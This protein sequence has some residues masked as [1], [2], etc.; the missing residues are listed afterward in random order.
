MVTPDGQKTIVQSPYMLS[1]FP[2][3]EELDLDYIASAKALHTTALRVDTAEK[4]MRHAKKEGVTTSFD[5]EKHV[6]NYGFEKLAPLIKLTD[7]LL[8]NK[9]GALTLTGAN[10]L[11]EAAE[12]LISLGPKLVVITR[13]DK[14][15]LVRTIHETLEVPAFKVIAIDTTGA[16]DAFNAGFIIGILRGWDVRSAATF[17]NAV[18]A[19]KITH[20]GAQTGLPTREEVEKF[21]TEQE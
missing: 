16:G 5:L 18:A 6:A 1:V 7:V 21:L 10:N 2:R 3:P 19:I 15:C 9:M 14:R 4:A 17:A 8:P 20:V 12:K 13:G 11:T